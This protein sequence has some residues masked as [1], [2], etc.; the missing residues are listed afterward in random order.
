[1]SR[2]FL[3]CVLSIVAAML[4]ANVGQAAT[5]QAKQAAID[6]GLAYLA[7]SQITS[8][9]YDGAWEYRRTYNSGPSYDGYLAA[10]A[11]AAL[12]FIEEGYTPGDGSIYDTHVTKA[13]NYIFDKA[14]VDPYYNNYGRETAGYTRYAEDYNND[15]VVNSLDVGRNNQAIYFDPY[16]SKRDIYT[17]G[18]VVPV[19]YA[20]GQALGKDTVVGTGSATVSGMTYKEVLRDVVD[21]YS[22]GQVE[23]GVVYGGYAQRG[24][25]RY[26]PNYNSSDNSTAQWGAL[27]LL[28]GEEWGLNAPDYVKN[29]LTLWVNLI[30]NDNTPSDWRDG[31]S[32]YSNPDQYVNDAKTGGL[33]LQLAAIGA[34]VNDP[35]VQAALGFLDGRWNDPAHYSHDEWF[36]GNLDNPYAMWA[37]YKGLEEFDVTTMSNAPG[38]FIV[39]QD[40]D[41]HTSAAGDWY[42]HYCDWLVNDQ[43]SDGSWDGF[44]SP[45]HNNRAYYWNGA[46][47]DG[48]YINILNATGLPEPVVPEPSTF[49]IWSLLGAGGIGFMSLRRRRSKLGRP[50]S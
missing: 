27:A 5:E 10:T 12:A 19:I 2:R 7:G 43:N 23:P 34:D 15:G 8:G 24:G 37:I 4:V 47:A 41:S 42:A 40:W 26:T 1:M 50:P 45:E 21:W 39:G 28:Y 48:W 13:V 16:N 35:R 36:H 9:T 22:Y 18:L 3:A 33:L 14:K 6:A 30:Q 49:V 46:L 32:G 29:E 11:S 25:W 38:G 44:E 31:G 20:L 17:N